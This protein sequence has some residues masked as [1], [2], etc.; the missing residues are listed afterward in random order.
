MSNNG[1]RHLISSEDWSIEEI[2]EALALARQ[3]RGGQNP[4]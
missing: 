2:D 4:P 3:L 1:S